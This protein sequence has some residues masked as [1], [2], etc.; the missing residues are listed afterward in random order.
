MAKVKSI[1]EAIA[2]E[3]AKVKEPEVV[4][5]EQPV[6]SPKP[7]NEAKEAE[8][9][10]YDNE[11]KMSKLVEEY[12]INSSKII[13]DIEE[14]ERKKLELQNDVFKKGGD[15]NVP[16]AKSI[17]DGATLPKHKGKLKLLASKAK[18]ISVI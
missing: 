4:I 8:D 18:D 6:V 14:Y 9:K 16:Y 7:K 11:M 12:K 10:Y 2:E 15:L 5:I 1:N 17:K 3:E 13:K